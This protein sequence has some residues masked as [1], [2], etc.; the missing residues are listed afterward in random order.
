LSI[1]NESRFF[2][3]CAVFEPQPLGDDRSLIA[4]KPS[5]SG[6]SGYQAAMSQ[7]VRA[8]ERLV[9][10]S[11]YFRG[12]A[13]QVKIILGPGTLGRSGHYRAQW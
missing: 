4:P 13:P 2:E 8:P 11:P 6:N 5:F 12:F 1:H 3:S 7:E 10:P 9:N